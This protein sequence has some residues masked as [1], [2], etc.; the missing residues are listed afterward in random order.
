MPFEDFYEKS[1]KLK[2]RY[3]KS[4]ISTFALSAVVIISFFGLYGIYK[5]YLT[6]YLKEQARIKHVDALCRNLPK[7]Q[8]F[9]FVERKDPL[10][11]NDNNATKVVYSYQTQRNANE[12]ISGFLRWFSANGW[13]RRAGDEWIFTKD[14]QTIA[15]TSTDNFSTRYDIHCSEQDL[16]FGI[17]D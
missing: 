10:S 11:Y 2:Y 12:I 6:E 8:M 16:S 14:G 4:V 7:P 1:D 5:D 3:R 13:K 15:I 17:Y 9:N